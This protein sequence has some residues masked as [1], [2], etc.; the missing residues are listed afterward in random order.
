MITA[1]A[2]KRSWFIPILLLISVFTC[3]CME[4]VTGFHP[5]VSEANESSRLLPSGLIPT[6]ETPSLPSPG[7]SVLITPNQSNTNTPSLLPAPPAKEYLFPLE[8]A[9]QLPVQPLLVPTRLP[10]GF[11]YQGGSLD[12]EGVVHLRI[13]NGSQEITYIQAPHWG[14]PGVGLTGPGIRL[15]SIPA[16]CLTFLCSETGMLH[17]IF[18]T[19]GYRDFYMIGEPGCDTLIDMA[20]SLVPLDYSILDQ[21][22]YTASDPENPFPNPE[23]I[24]IILPLSWINARYPDK[25]H[26]RMYDITIP[27]DEFNASFTPDPR[28][29]SIL[30]HTDV[31]ENETVVYLSLPETLYIQFSV[32]PEAIRL[33]YPK[34]Y[35]VS[36]A[37]M[38]SLYEAHWRDPPPP[39]WKPRNPGIPG[40]IPVTPDTLPRTGN[41]II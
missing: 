17:Q 15:Q 35:F 9:P 39:G 29:P 13:T 30:R 8:E 7:V 3:G 40:T 26:S 33:R 32:E 18:W 2:L 6:P 24:R 28:D 20:E 31:R 37:N 25:Y 4:E 27:S 14:D 38:E 34:D 5:G 16:G 21:L 11:S 41:R 19:D 23:R 36:F 10:V 1:D 12:R 22:P